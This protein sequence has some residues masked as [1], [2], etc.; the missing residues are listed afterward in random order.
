MQGRVDVYREALINGSFFSG[1]LR[2]PK[3]LGEDL[4]YHGFEHGAKERAH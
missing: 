3:G 1:L 4:C 2:E